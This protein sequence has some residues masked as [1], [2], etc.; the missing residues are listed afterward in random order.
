M[1]SCAIIIFRNGKADSAIEMKNAWLGSAF[2]WTKL[3]DKHVTK[4]FKYD[5]WLNEPQRL[6]DLKDSDKL[7]KCEKV[8]LRMTF[9]NVLIRK[10]DF[11]RLTF[12][13][14]LFET[15]HDRDGSSHLPL[16]RECLNKLS[17]DESVD[18]IGFWGTTVCDN[19][20]YSWDEE[21]EDEVPYDIS[22][23]EE[24]WFLEI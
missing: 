11:S 18:A 14:S 6:W 13:I 23:G 5:S 21:K 17:E 3:F 12:F 16:I 10:E 24:H 22:T 2:V 15:F 1:S 7:E 8:V 19:P 9:D 20:W 4:R